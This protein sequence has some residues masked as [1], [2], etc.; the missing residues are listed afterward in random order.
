MVLLSS[1][2]F[3]NKINHKNYTMQINNIISQSFMSNNDT[4]VENALQNNS[5]IA[6]HQVDNIIV[7]AGIGKEDPKTNNK[8]KTLYI[9]TFATLENYRGKGY[10]KKI[11]KQFLKK[12]GKTHIIYLTV[13]TEP[14][15]FNESAIKCYSKCGF[16][17]LPQVYRDHYDGKNSCM[18]RIPENNKNKKSKKKKSKKK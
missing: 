18:I 12:F 6:Y 3:I 16:I 10:C 13:R 5:F 2:E 9:H 11:V 4:A 17:M 15:N 1:S 14:G 8:Y 7:S